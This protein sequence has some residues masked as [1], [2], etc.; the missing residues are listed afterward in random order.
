[1]YRKAVSHVGAEL[2][3]R[4]GRKGADGNH[5]SL[6][7]ADIMCFGGR[8]EARLVCYLHPPLVDQLGE[9]H[10]P[11]AGVGRCIAKSALDSHLPFLLRLVC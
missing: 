2:W 5:A 11:L 1:M 9:R 4:G 8:L 3:A 10:R 7:G 6:E